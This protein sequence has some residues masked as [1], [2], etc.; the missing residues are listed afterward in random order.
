MAIAHDVHL[1]HRTLIE[2]EVCRVL[3]RDIVNRSREDWG[4]GRGA[5][6]RDLGGVCV[7][8][9]I[10][11]VYGAGKHAVPKQCGNWVHT[12]SDR[13]LVVVWRSD[14]F[15]YFSHVMSC[16]G[17]IYCSFFLKQYLKNHR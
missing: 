4:L 12:V 14:C 6:E 9:M 3:G 13:V 11:R 10:V 7:D 8:S 2:A 1:L 5:R 15:F 17:Y 16:Y